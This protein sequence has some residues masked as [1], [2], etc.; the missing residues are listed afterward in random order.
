MKFKIQIL[1]VILLVLSMSPV[2]ALLL[3]NTNL[4]NPI[5]TNNSSNKI[6]TKQQ[7]TNNSSINQTKKT[8]NTRKVNFNSLK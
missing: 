8:N 4:D 5:K 7:I 1:F 3:S 2:S 6:V